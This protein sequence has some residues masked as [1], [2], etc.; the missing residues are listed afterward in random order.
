M[1]IMSLDPTG[2]GRKTLDDALEIRPERVESAF[3]GRPAAG[4]K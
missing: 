3:D 4:W 2:A 1:A